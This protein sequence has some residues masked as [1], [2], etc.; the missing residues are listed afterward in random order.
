MIIIYSYI[1]IYNILNEYSFI[2]NSIIILRDLLQLQ[3]TIERYI[4]KQKKK[5]ILPIIENINIYT[6]TKNK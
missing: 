6:T 1:F 5:K 2:H 4:Y 3:L